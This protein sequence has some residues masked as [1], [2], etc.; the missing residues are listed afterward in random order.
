MVYIDPKHHDDGQKVAFEVIGP[1]GRPLPLFESLAE[2]INSR[3]EPYFLEVNAIS[4]AQS[5]WD[6]VDTHKGE[7]TSVTFEFVAPNMFGHDEDYAKDMAE[8]KKNE[9]IQKVKL[10]LESD[11]GLVLNTNRV[12]GAVN[13]AVQGG[14]SIKAKTKSKQIFH[15]KSKV[16]KVSIT[17]KKLKKMSIPE[18]FSMLFD[19]ILNR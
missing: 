1:I 17:K 15:S 6:F 19:R 10:S 13:Y 12:Q 16:K 5:F 8:M 9:N 11:D 2:Y 18:L 3:A 7:I 14:G 4:N